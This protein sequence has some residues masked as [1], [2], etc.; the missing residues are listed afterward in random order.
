MVNIKDY[1]DGWSWD[2]IGKRRKNHTG[3]HR[4]SRFDKDEGSPRMI[5][6]HHRHDGGTEPHPI[7]DHVDELADLLGL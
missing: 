1:D 6:I 7:S 2:L 5:A 3:V 4:H